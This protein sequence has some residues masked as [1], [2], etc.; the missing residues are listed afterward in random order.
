M[1]IGSRFI[2]TGV[3]YDW[4]LGRECEVIG[5]VGGCWKV[6]VLGTDSTSLMNKAMFPLPTRTEEEIE[7]L[8]KKGKRYWRVK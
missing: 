5:E 6:K 4:R 8:K 1:N 3:S 2:Y 7:R